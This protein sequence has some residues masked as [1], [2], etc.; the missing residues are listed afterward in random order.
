MDALSRL[1][2]ADAVDRL[3]NR[4]AT[5]FASDAEELALVEDS[6]GWADLASVLQAAP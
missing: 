5:L 1:A 3:R 6:L 2:S 4:D